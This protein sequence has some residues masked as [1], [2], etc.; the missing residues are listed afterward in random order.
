MFK[1]IFSLLI[2]LLTI[3]NSYAFLDM[4]LGASNS[5]L[6][7]LV[8]RNGNPYSSG[9]ALTDITITIRCAGNTQVTVDETGD[10]ITAYEDGIHLITT[11]DAIGND[12]EDQC[13]IRV[14]GQSGTS[15]VGS[16]GESLVYMD[17]KFKSVGATVDMG[18]GTFSGTVVSSV[19]CTN[20]Q[21]IFDTNLTQTQ[22][23]HWKDAFITFTSG[24]LAGQTRPVTAFNATTKC[25]T[26]RS[27]GF[28]TIPTAGDGFVIINK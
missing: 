17:E 15:Y 8:D 22:T 21:T 25:I 19:D 13:Y 4:K 9:L 28:T 26:I 1:Y 11:N 24:T 18:I 5:F 12:A 2:V 3:T 6:V 16:Q 23:D 27:P 14:A 10:G 7:R 20:S